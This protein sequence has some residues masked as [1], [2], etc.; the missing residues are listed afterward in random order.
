MSHWFVDHRQQFIADTLRVFGQIN[1]QTLC[2]RFDISTP[3]ASTDLTLF[4]K[5]NPGAMIYDGRAKC[6]IV[7]EDAL[8]APRSA[9]VRVVKGFADE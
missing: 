2:D 7:A 8:P 6:Y 4:M 5:L 1:R 9:E 3:Q